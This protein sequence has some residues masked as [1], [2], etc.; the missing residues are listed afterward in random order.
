MAFNGSFS[1]RVAK[2]AHPHGVANACAAQQF[3]TDRLGWS[4]Q[5]FLVQNGSVRLMRLYKNMSANTS[6]T[7]MFCGQERF[8]SNNTPI[9]ESLDVTRFETYPISGFSEHQS[10]A[11]DQTKFWMTQIQN[12]KSRATPVK[13]STSSNI[14]QIDPN[15]LYQKSCLWHFH[16]LSRLVH[17]LLQQ[18]HRD[19][20]PRQDFLLAAVLVL[21]LDAHGHGSCSK[22]LQF[23][24]QKVAPHMF[25]MCS[26]CSHWG[27]TSRPSSWSNL[28]FNSRPPRRS[29]MV[30][31]AKWCCF[32]FELFHVVSSKPV[33]SRCF[34]GT[35]ASWGK[36]S[37]YFKCLPSWRSSSEV[38][39]MER[40][41][42]GECWKFFGLFQLES[43]FEDVTWKLQAT[44][45]IAKGSPVWSFL[46]TKLTATSFSCKSLS[47]KVNGRR[48]FPKLATD[49]P[50]MR[51][52]SSQK[53][54][55][56]TLMRIVPMS[57]TQTWMCC[58]PWILGFLMIPESLCNGLGAQ[59]RFNPQGLPHPAAKSW[60][61]K[62]LSES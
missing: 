26:P 52:I 60:R 11:S 4:S 7:T 15:L 10:E 19:R 42:T 20:Q 59:L 38:A 57:S 54:L 45:I 25:D 14:H 16:H 50:K 1:N 41:L 2:S 35:P 62:Q 56:I 23:L 61:T 31:C 28:D 34:G 30:A 3:S 5:Q 24:F 33:F 12:T 44:F 29:S 17:C 8:I 6:K 53:L 58:F 46:S 39:G 22:D 55:E 36:T 40:F 47:F 21:Q 43:K 48:A 32:I 51:E 37:L 49:V 9:L 18:T 27:S 13:S